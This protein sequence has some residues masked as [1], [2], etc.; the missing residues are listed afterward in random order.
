MTG[1]LLETVV[2]YV[3]AA[4]IALAVATL[5]PDVVNRIQQT[6]DTTTTTTRKVTL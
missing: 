4:A 2:L 5:L 1:K 6:L 3:L